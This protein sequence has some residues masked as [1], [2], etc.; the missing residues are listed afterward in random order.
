MSTMSYRMRVALLFMVVSRHVE[1]AEA[2]D[3]KQPP[4]ANSTVVE[5]LQQAAT[6]LATTLAQGAMARR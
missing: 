3:T 2:G 4:V 1:L 5:K 6:A